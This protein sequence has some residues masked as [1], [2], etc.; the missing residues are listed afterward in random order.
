VEENGSGQP[1]A[2]RRVR[3]LALPDFRRL[4]VVGLVLFVVRWLEMLAVGVFA[5]WSAPRE[6][7]H[8]LG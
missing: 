5:Y 4:W 3:L 1:A 7:V 8:P 6:V 2:S